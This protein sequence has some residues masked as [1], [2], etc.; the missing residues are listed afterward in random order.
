MLKNFKTLNG[1]ELDTLIGVLGRA[2]NG[3]ALLAPE[4]EVTVNLLE[5]AARE[6][7]AREDN[8]PCD[9]HV[10]GC[11]TVLTDHFHGGWCSPHCGHYRA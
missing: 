3:M 9:P 1:K 8:G 10:S 6:S 5:D 7:V 11:E 4:R 2:Y